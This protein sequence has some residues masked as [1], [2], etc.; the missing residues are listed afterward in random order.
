MHNR[1]GPPLTR[2]G[3]FSLL[4][5]VAGESLSHDA[6]AAIRRLD[7]EQWYHGQLLETLLNS[8]EDQDPE[9]A[10]FVGRN[11]YFMFRTPLQNAG[12]NSATEL[13][14]SMPGTWIYATRG[15]CGEWRSRQ[16]ADHHWIV[17]AEQPY[18]CI[19]EAGALR[20]FIEAFDGHDVQIKHVTCRRKGHPCCTYDVQ[21]KE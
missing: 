12:V 6:H 18:N 7:S 8:L 5:T 11:I 14:K 4:A 15:D 21:W 16:V 17:E 20:G 13:V 3:L 10:E 1:V 19:F 2:G 9:L